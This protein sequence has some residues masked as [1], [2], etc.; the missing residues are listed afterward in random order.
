MRAVVTGGAGFIGSH[1]VDALLARGDEVH[2]VD[3]LETGRRENVPHHGRFALAT[4]LNTIGWGS[5]QILDYLSSTPN[6]DREKS[7]YQVEHVT[8]QKGVQAYTPPGCATIDMFAASPVY[9]FP[10]VASFSRYADPDRVVSS[11]TVPL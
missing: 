9:V 2:V 4:F 11:G 7:R 6:F 1:V 3:T 5:E 10:R 8:G